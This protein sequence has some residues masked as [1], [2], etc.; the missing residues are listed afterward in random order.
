MA[1]TV[2]MREKD[3]KLGKWF[4]KIG[5]PITKFFNR[6]PELEPNIVTLYAMIGVFSLFYVASRIAGTETLESKLVPAAV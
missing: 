3:N 4:M 5:T 1:Y 2:G 6:L